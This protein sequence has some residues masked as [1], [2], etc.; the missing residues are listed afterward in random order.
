MFSRRLGKP[1]LA[2]AAWLAGLALMTALHLWAWPLIWHLVLA[3]GLA[4]ERQ[5]LEVLEFA[6]E[7]GRGKERASRLE[8]GAALGLAEPDT[9][10]VAYGAWRPPRAGRWELSL[11]CDDYGNLVLDRRRVIDLHGITD[12]NQGQAVLELDSGPHLLII[13]LHNRLGQ[14]WLRLLAKGPGQDDFAPIPAD[15]LRAFALGNYRTW[16]TAAAWIERAAL[17][18]LAALLAGGLVLWA[19]LATRAPG[20][21]GWRRR[22]AGAGFAAA[23]LVLALVTAWYTVGLHVEWLN[24]LSGHEYL[25]FQEWDWHRAIVES[26]HTDHRNHRILPEYLLAGVYGL[27]RGHEG[28]P[29]RVQLLFWNRYAIDAALLLA[30][31]L[32]FRRLGLSRPSVL[33]GMAILAWAL[34][35]TRIRNSLNPATFLDVVFYLAAGAFTAAGRIR[36]LIPLTVLAALNKETSILI[37]LLPLAGAVSFKRPW[38]LPRPELQVAAWGLGLWLLV[39]IGIRLATGW[40]WFAKETDRPGWGF[41]VF[42]LQEDPEAWRQ[43]YTTFGVLPFICL[44]YLRRL[45]RLLQGFFWLVAPVWF[46][47]HLAMSIWAETRQLLAPMALVFVPGCLWL[48]RIGGP[49]APAGPAGPRVWGGGEAAGAGRG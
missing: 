38:R 34:Y 47:V 32:Y 18:G 49:S 8:P 30:A 44:A 25:A 45:P 43:L 23:C 48:A 41:V 19:Y 15:Q 9:A 36:H 17:A 35:P 1:A 24:V 42:N 14:G 20:P 29:D 27:L 12:H 26:R 10:A 31:A 6:N 13:R 28:D 3:P 37:P 7:Q 33:L 21:L 2:V 16:L 5:G 39:F 22:L 46:L 4:G 11:E 40:E